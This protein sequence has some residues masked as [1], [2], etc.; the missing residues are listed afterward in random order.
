MTAGLL[1]VS[2]P[3]GMAAAGGAVVLLGVAIALGARRAPQGLDDI[4][5]KFLLQALRAAAMH[6]E[7]AT[8]AAVRLVAIGR[9]IAGRRHGSGVAAAQRPR[10][11]MPGS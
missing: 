1:G 10:R 3:P 7:R 9:G 4:A 6:L 11:A 2:S 5:R 8:E